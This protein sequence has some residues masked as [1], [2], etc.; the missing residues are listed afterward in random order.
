MSTSAGLAHVT[1]LWT[2]PLRIRRLGPIIDIMLTTKLLTTK[3]LHVFTLLFCPD[4]VTFAPV[5]GPYLAS[6]ERQATPPS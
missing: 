1:T 4:S 5:Y 2:D 6:T 3:E